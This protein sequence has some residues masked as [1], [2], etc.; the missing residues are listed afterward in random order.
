MILRQTPSDANGRPDFNSGPSALYLGVLHVGDKG[1]HALRLTHSHVH[2]LNTLP[3]RHTS[4]DSLRCQ[5]T[6]RFQLRAICTLPVRVACWRRR[7][8][9]LAL[10]PFSCCILARPINTH[11]SQLN[12]PSQETSNT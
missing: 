5:W 9:H 6:P 12:E 1:V 3:H 8:P 2:L 4:S 11:D 10:A 7:R